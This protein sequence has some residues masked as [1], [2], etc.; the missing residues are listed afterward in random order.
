[1]EKLELVK[2]DLLGIE[3]SEYNKVKR[4]VIQVND[5][6]FFKC[7]MCHIWKN[8]VKD[9]YRDTEFYE[10]FFSDLK[11]IK[12]DDTAIT[13][14]G[15]EPLTVPNIYE[16]VNASIKSG[17]ETNINSNGWLLNQEN[18]K[19][20]HNVR[21]SCMVFSVDGSCPKIHDDIRGMPGSFDRIISAVEYIKKYT[22]QMGKEMGTQFTCV[23]SNLNIKD[24]VSLAELTNKL[25]YVD[26]L[27][28]QAVSAPFRA[29][30][31]VNGKS[32]E[33]EDYV[34][35]YAHTKYRDLWPKDKKT[36][37]DVFSTLIQLKRKGYKISNSEFHL[38]TFYH[39][40]INPNIRQKNTDCNV[41]HDLHIFPP[42]G[43]VFI[44]NR[45]LKDKPI[46]NINNETI[47]AIWNSNAAR[48]LRT[49]MIECQ[50]PCH[51]V[52]NCN[53]IEII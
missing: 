50:Q 52:M 11:K 36:L 49:N 13:L 32:I 41:I 42:S 30:D 40:F 23:I 46:G 31:I 20:L 47:D 33:N 43:D 37:T 9:I 6:C 51:E 34:D 12:G 17:F 15:G 1:M 21:L 35:W 24:I 4:V 19:K 14:T 22:L 26:K 3:Q 38:K 53:S 44:C 28:F 8:K 16:I 39:Y 48:S 2:N 7:Q 18:I 10:R 45:V 5:T 25:K 29:E 27:W